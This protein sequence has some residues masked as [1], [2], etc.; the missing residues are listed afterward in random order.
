LLL[1]F[2]ISKV[3]VERKIGVIMPAITAANATTSTVIPITSHLRARTLFTNAPNVGPAWL[4]TL[5]T[6]RVNPVRFA[7]LGG[8]LEGIFMCI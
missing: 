6:R 7:K 4:A 1:L 2:S 3:V 8:R 5:L